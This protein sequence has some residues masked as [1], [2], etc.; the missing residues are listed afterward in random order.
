MGAAAKAN[1]AL[2]P[3]N[4]NKGSVSQGCVAVDGDAWGFKQGNTKTVSLRKPA[5]AKSP[6]SPSGGK[7]LGGAKGKAKAVAKAGTKSAVK[8]FSSA[9]GGK[10]ST[11]LVKKSSHGMTPKRA[12]GT[13]PAANPSVATL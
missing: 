1:P 7:V 5:G 9:T 4:G 3:L 12:K 8:N 6:A 13:T 10:K 2:A 11:K